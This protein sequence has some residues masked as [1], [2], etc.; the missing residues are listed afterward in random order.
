MKISRKIIKC[1]LLEITKNK[2]KKNIDKFVALTI[3]IKKNGE[4][5]IC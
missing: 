1:K 3:K 5:A 2:R 4:K